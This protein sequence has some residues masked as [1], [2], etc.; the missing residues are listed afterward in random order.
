MKFKYIL[1]CFVYIILWPASIFASSLLYLE[2]FDDG[3]IDDP[4]VGSIAAVHDAA[5]NASDLN[6]LCVDPSNYHIAATGRGGTGYAFSSCS[7]SSDQ[8]PVSYLR[9]LYNAQW[10]TNEMYISFWMKYT[11]YSAGTAGNQNFKFF[12]PHWAGTN[13][14]V[15]YALYSPTG[16][17]F[18]S[19][20]NDASGVITLNNYPSGGADQED[21]DWHHYEFYLN[22]DTDI[23]RMWYDSNLIVDEDY[24]DS[25]WANPAT[26]YYVTF[27]E[28]DAANSSGTASTFDA[29]VIDDIEVWDGM[30][31]TSVAALTGTAVSGGCTESEIVA[32]GQTIIITLTN[33]TWETFDNTIRAA[34]VAGLDSAQSELGGWDAKIKADT[35][36]WSATGV[37][38][39]SDTV[40]TITLPATADYAIAATETITAT[41]PASTLVTSTEAVVATPTF[42]VYYETPGSVSGSS[43][44][45]STGSV[46]IGSGNGG[47]VIGSGSSGTMVP[48]GSGEIYTTVTAAMAGVDANAGDTFYLTSDITDNVVWGSNDYGSADD[49]VILD[50]NGH[51]ITASGV[52]PG[53]SISG[54]IGIKI[55]DGTI[56]VSG[57]GTSGV[58]GQTYNYDISYIWVDNVTVT[59]ADTNGI[60]FYNRSADTTSA[61]HHVYVSDCTVTNAGENG[62]SFSGYWSLHDNYVNG[63][64]VTGSNQ[65]QAERQ[66]ISFI[67]IPIVVGTGDWVQVGVTDTYYTILASPITAADIDR[68]YNQTEVTL[69]TANDGNYA[70]LGTN[71]WDATNTE[72]GQERLYVRITAI[73]G[74]LVNYSLGLNE[75]FHIYDNEIIG[76]FTE[77]G[78]GTDGC[79]IFID[80]NC[81]DGLI[82][83]NKIH[84]NYGYGLRTK[85][86]SD[87]H[88]W[89]NL[90]YNNGLTTDGS[91]ITAYVSDN[92]TNIDFSNCT[93]DADGSEYAIGYTHNSSGDIR[94]CII[95][96]A[97]THGIIEA[98]TGTVTEDYN[99][100]YNNTADRSGVAVGTHSFDSDP[101]FTNYVG[102]DY[103]LTGTSPCRDTGVI[104]TGVLYDILGAIPYGPAPDV[105]AYEFATAPGI[106]TN[107]A[108][109]GSIGC[110][111]AGTGSVS[112]GN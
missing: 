83:Q 101:L 99:D 75:D 91:D 103:S 77:T 87:I 50:L 58:Y 92:S 102:F 55:Q 73:T 46:V 54:L 98:S 4:L 79:G 81:D 72:G 8:S 44:S 11:N 52:G 112:F 10:P 38:R 100:L 21:G 94:N 70:T 85:A 89:S 64:S 22:F 109:T 88:W 18:Y 35:G 53:V 66:G 90:A 41:I 33:D 78:S 1:F 80:W 47:V 15:H 45:G 86:S 3:D 63:C 32:G 19:A 93:I 7:V 110:D 16:S 71:Q 30:S 6:A 76:T 59:G 2:N 67:C 37:V 49:P 108:G 40:C 105:G 28:I 96:D 56:A 95:M 51:T 5:Q 23:S 57:S 43:F 9:W 39:T 14:Y 42:S 25:S 60:A 20:K 111:T 82:Y 17:F 106:G 29:R 48:V 31:G 107:V 61:V 27:G 68:V 69:L 13:A 74:D 97:T 34:I 24:S 65:D 84:G 36:A 26:I 12:Y 104:V 62:I